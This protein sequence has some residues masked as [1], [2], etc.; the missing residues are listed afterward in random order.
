M[1]HKMKKI[2][3]KKQRLIG[4]EIIGLHTEKYRTL[5]IVLASLL[6][7]LGIFLCVYWNYDENFAGEILD[8]VYFTVIFSLPQ[9]L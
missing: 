9:Y 5:M 1:N 6:M 4:M 3:I 7:S 2:D 8:Y